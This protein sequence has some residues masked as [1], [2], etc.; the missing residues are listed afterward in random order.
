MKL[1]LK[2]AELDTE[3]NGEQWDE[4]KFLPF[5][6]AAEQ[7][8][9]VLFFHP[10]P[11]NNFLF[12]RIPRHG[13]SNSL[14]VI[15]DDGHGR[16]GTG[17]GAAFAQLCN[18]PLFVFDQDKDGWFEWTGAD[19][20]SSTHVDVLT[21]DCDVWIDDDQVIARG[22]YLLEELGLDGAERG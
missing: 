16:G 22:H 10:Q 11:Q 6:K 19:W 13:L 9:A 8:G 17:W 2:G 20:K 18:K 15:L 12:Q 7:M 4:A 3:V 21:R 1:G 5:F 14:G